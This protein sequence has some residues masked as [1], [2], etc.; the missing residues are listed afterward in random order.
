[1][2]LFIAFAIMDQPE[3]F[4]ALLDMLNA[5]YGTE[6]TGDGVVELGKKVLSAERDF[7]KRAGFT[8]ADD[9]LPRFFYTDPIAPHN[10]VFSMKDEELDDG[11]QLVIGTMTVMGGAA[12]RASPRCLD[13]KRDWAP[14]DAR[15]HGES[16]DQL[17]CNWR[18][19]C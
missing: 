7:N 11:L 9:R 18:L 16:T 6:L 14:R 12:R 1:M 19:N 2:C 10:Q 8:K 17:R 15:G 4:Q 13:R 5:F 3:T